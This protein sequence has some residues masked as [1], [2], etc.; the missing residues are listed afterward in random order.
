MPDTPDLTPPP[1]QPMPDEARAHIRDQLAA[2]T[3]GGDAGQGSRGVSLLAGRWTAPAVAAAAVVAVVLGAF[4]VA[5]T[6]DNSS[7]PGRDSLQPAATSPDAP[8]P[9]VT[10]GSE[11]GSPTPTAAEEATPTPS[12]LSVSLGTPTHESAAPPPKTAEPGFPQL[13]D[14]APVSC[15]EE[16]AEMAQMEPSLRGAAVTAQRDTAIG[17]IY[18]YETKAAGVV[19]DDTTAVPGGPQSEKGYVP[20]LISF[21]QKSEDYRLDS[22]T[23]AISQNYIA[24]PDG[25]YSY[26]FAAGRDF[27]GVE[28]ISYT[29]P[30]GHTEDA[31]LGKNGFWSMSYLPTEGVLADPKTNT[32]RLDPIKVTL[33]H[34]YDDFW[35]ASLEW[36]LDTCAQLNHGC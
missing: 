28:A 11:T 9:T 34:S 15:D 7:G 22:E 2:A 32:F 20:T 10:P 16:V 23:L 3:A 21:H 29:F 27:D 19:C 18:L 8:P 12:E 24:S 31:V 36:G 26:F 14:E 25:A 17:T 33:R 30:D 5:A 6:Q 1:E 35:V 4:A 13:P